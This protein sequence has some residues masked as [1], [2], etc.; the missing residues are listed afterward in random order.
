MNAVVA[1][2]RTI[3][4]GYDFRHPNYC[5]IFA[6]RG[7]L[8][9]TCKQR[10]S[11][12]RLRAFYRENPDRFINDWGMTFDPRN[13][14]VGLPA[15]L[16][17]ILFPKQVELIQTILAQWRAREPLLI[18][19]TR[20]T[21][22]T[23]TVVALAVTMCLH[24]RGL[25]IGFGSRKEVYVDNGS[26]PKSIFFKVR[27]FLSNL[28][29]ELRGGWT[30]DN[31]PFMRT[32]IPETGSVIT[33]E[34]GDGIGRGDR[35]SL[36]FVDE[37]AFLERPQTT[38][39]SLS[40]TTNCRIDLST[41]NGAANPFAIK[42][43][44]GKVKVFILDWRDDPRK[45]QAWYEKQERLLDPVTLAQEVNRDY[46]ASMT[47]LIIPARWVR[48]A[49]DAHVALGITPTGVRRGALDVADEGSDANA[50]A[51]RHGI[52]LESVCS[53]SGKDSDIFHTV[54][55]AFELT[56]A[57]RYTSFLYDAD[58]LGAGVRGDALR[59][60]E[61][62]TI[63]GRERINDE[64]FRGSA[65]VVDPEGEMVLERK[66]ED[67]FANLKAQS[68]WALRDRFQETHR[69]R[70]GEPYDADKIISIPSDLPELLQLQSELAQPTYK[71]NTVGKVVIDK[72]PEG[73]KSPN[74]ADAVMM[75]FSPVDVDAEIWALLGRKR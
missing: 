32:T 14:E 46:L 9:A 45:D 17:L 70:M 42:R 35:T 43:H 40:Q 4:D 69:A 19:K 7:Q 47:G 30:L 65:S 67:F 2:L 6:R 61:D 48:D 74:L 27:Y 34:A 22:A 31:S 41:P 25:T 75:V 63:S 56:E 37:S 18:E 38:E 72:K 23:W 16:P 66:N 44:S 21:G 71:I 58:G 13:I 24:Y 33:G 52:L 10:D 55:K 20:D 50:Y 39:H 11:F 5:K 73:A 54:I 57:G 3:E 15:H 36:Y 12:R 8:Y 26:D 51:G 29:A 68:W 64:P 60:N 59:L 53:W 28:P 1:S 49:I 62:R